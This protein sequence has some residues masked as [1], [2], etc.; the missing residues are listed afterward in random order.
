ME[1][2]VPDMGTLMIQKFNGEDGYIEQMGQK[3][4]Y[5][6]EQKTEQKNET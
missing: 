3:I 2:S 1:M 6:D 5:D 4:P